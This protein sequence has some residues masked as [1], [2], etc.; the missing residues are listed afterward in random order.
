MVLCCD[1]KWHIVVQWLPCLTMEGVYF[2]LLVQLWSSVTVRGE[3][4]NLGYFCTFMDDLILSIGYGT[5]HQSTQPL[6]WH[7]FPI[8]RQYRTLLV[9]SSALQRN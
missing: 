8:W 9:N 7:L 3:K 2:V 4:F 1:G 5:I 6:Q